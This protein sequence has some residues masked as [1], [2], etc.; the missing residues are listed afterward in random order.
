[1][2][3]AETR[4]SGQLGINVIRNYLDIEINYKQVLSYHSFQLQ[5][6]V[7]N[8]RK[9]QNNSGLYKAEGYFS[10]TLK[11]SQVGASPVAQWLNLACCAL[12]DQVQFS[13]AD[14]HHSLVTMLLWRPTHKIQ[15]DWQQM[16][17]QGNV[18][19]FPQQKEKSPMGFKQQT[20]V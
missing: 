12:A 2:F 10:P 19:S 17:A 14:L 16:L 1:M 7:H 11:N 13:V 6:R 3:K 18:S 4:N 5:L 20:T 9:P 15:E 8:N